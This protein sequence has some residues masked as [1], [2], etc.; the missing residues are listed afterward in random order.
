[1]ATISRLPKNIG[2]FCKRSVRP[3][4]SFRVIC[5]L[6]MLI[7]LH[8]CGPIARR[9][10]GMCMCACMHVCMHACVHVYACVCACVCKRGCVCMCGHV[11]VRACVCTCMS[12]CHV[13]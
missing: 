1:V 6:S 3:A 8:V 12:K 5:V 13:L 2:L 11:C 10:A 9:Y 4:A 7:I